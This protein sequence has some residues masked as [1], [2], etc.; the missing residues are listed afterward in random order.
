[1]RHFNILTSM[2]FL[3]FA[4]ALPLQA[5]ETPVKIGHQLSCTGEIDGANG[6]SLHVILQ[7][8]DSFRSSEN[9][10]PPTQVTTYLKSHIQ[11]GRWFAI[12]PSAGQTPGQLFWIYQRTG[13]TKKLIAYGGYG[14]KMVLSSTRP[15]LEIVVDPRLKFD[16]FLE[17][18]EGNLVKTSGYLAL[19]APSAPEPIV[20]QDLNCQIEPAAKQ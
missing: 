12:V 1:M 13:D 18:G 11:G 10:T 8:S 16:L 3:S 7:N 5:A 19:R 6:D 4:L 2:L 14:A 20:A 17:A 15:R 9:T